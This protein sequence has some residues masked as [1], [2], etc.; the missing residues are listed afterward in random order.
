MTST[1]APSALP[2]LIQG[3]MGV[4]ISN[5]KLARA[6]AQC[7]HLGVVSGTAI[8]RVIACRLQEGDSDGSLRRAFDAFPNRPLADR[9]YNRWYQPEGLPKPGVYRPLPMFNITSPAHLLELAVL[10]AFAEVWLAKNGSP[11]PVGINLLEKIQAPTLPFLYGALLARADYVLMGAGIPRDIPGHLDRLSQHQSCSLRLTVDERQEELLPF[12]P[13][14]IGCG[15]VTLQRPR[16]LAI[17]SSHVLAM[18]L[19]RSGGVDGFVVE[20]HVAGGHN[21]GP[22]GWSPATNDAP[23][24]GPRDE[25]DLAKIRSLGLPFWLAGGQDEPKALPQALALGAV[26]IQVGSAFAF[27]AESGMEPSLRRRAIAAMLAGEVEVVSEGRGSPTGFP[28]KVLPLPGSEGGR[29]AEERLR[30]PCTHGYLRSAYHKEDGSIGWRCPAEPEKDY[31]A[32]GGDIAD[33]SD[34]RCLCRGLLA[35]AGHPHQT[36]NGTLDIPLV[37]AGTVRSL[38]LYL[39]NNPDYSARDVIELLLTPAPLPTS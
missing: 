35:T 23:A 12:D 7:G 31:V 13:A 9:V 2:T 22:R 11:G 18:S 33:C 38:P 30:Q 29:L 39:Q 37:T 26:G 6:V 1:Q 32:K 15:H 36:R 14:P 17:I 19:A 8:E 4:A 16:F 20:G 28:F 34:R 25:V 27:C 21:A 5:W 10:A 3:G 24:Y